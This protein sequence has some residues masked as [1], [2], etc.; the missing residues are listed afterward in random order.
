MRGERRTDG[1]VT[2]VEAAFALPILFMFIMGLADLGMWTFNSNQA[3]NAARDGARM[4]IIDYRTADDPA[5]DTFKAVVDRIESRL[6]GRSLTVEN[7]EIE[8]VRADGGTGCAGAHPDR[9]R[10]RVEVDWSW[11]LVT[12]VAGIVGVDEGAASGTATMRIIGKA[13]SAPPADPPATTTSTSTTTTTSTSTIPPGTCDVTDLAV[14]P[15]PATLKNSAGSLNV[16]SVT[17]TATGTGCT[18]LAVQLSP[19]DSER[20][21]SAT[22]KTCGSTS[23]VWEYDSNDKVWS[24][25][26]ASV[27]V[28]NANVDTSAAFEVGSTATCPAA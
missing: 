1:G 8:C 26:C 16:V 17:F 28:F 27:R 2:I 24:T 14:S 22:C 6:A 7:V 9:D 23:N 3:T 12:P 5:S 21:Q 13:G 18:G 20:V 11:D 4:A 15:S 19:P 10:I 25:G